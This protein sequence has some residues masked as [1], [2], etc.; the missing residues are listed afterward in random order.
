LNRKA[1][2]SS[3]D[4]V[5]TRQ[6]DIEHARLA[7]LLDVRRI[8]WRGRPVADFLPAHLRQPFL[9]AMA[10]LNALVDK[11]LTAEPVPAIQPVSRHF[12]G[13]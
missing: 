8:G 7:R 6:R 1:T 12:L 5:V 2:V 13:V 4:Y 10:R 3:T 11:P 9:D